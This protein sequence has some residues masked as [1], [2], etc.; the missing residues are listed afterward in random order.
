MKNPF[1]RSRPAIEDPRP[2]QPAMDRKSAGWGSM[3]SL[4]TLGSG[5]WSS[6]DYGSLARNGYMKNPVAYR[7]VRL[8]SELAAAVPLL[9]YEGA[10]ELDEHPVLTLLQRPNVRQG[11]K[12]FLE[13]LFGHLL[14]SGNAYVELATIEGE[15]KEFHLLRPDRMRVLEDRRG[16][17]EGYEYRAGSNVRRH[18]LDERGLSPVLHLTLFHPLDD[19]YG[20]PPLQAAGMALDVHNASSEWNKALL[21]NSAR[22]SGALVYAPDQNANLSDE[23]FARLKNELEDGYTG[24]RQA[25]RPLLLEGGL[26]WK[27]MGYSPKDMDFVEGRHAAARDIA[28]AFGIPPMLLGIPGDNTY[29]NYQEANRALARQT[30]LPMIGRTLDAINHWLAPRYDGEFRIGYD[31][32]RIEGLAQER[33]SLWARLS[34]ADFLSEAEKR[35]AVGYSPEQGA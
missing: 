24:A 31:E 7:C 10:R 32:D 19:V 25:G 9:V 28:L 5:I 12:D 34:Q 20:F 1:R 30:I 6:P 3:V 4:A 11:S 16:W 2:A 33:D 15:P 22:P 17:V 35:E 26:D 23:Q 21:D 13:S 29:S 14:V 27:A 18:L 8:V